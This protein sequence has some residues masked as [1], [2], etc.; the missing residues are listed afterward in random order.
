MSDPFQV[1]AAVGG[2]VDVG[3]RLYTALGTLAKETSSADST[4]AAIRNKVTEL[5]ELLKS[6]QKTYKLRINTGLDDHEVDIWKTIRAC[7]ERCEATLRRYEEEVTGLMD[8]RSR[9]G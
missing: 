3:I 8:P 1:V 9:Y 5:T 2:C 7:L 4:V 6:V